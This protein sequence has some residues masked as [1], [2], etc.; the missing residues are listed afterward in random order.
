MAL[1]GG[2]Q[3]APEIGGRVTFSTARGD[4]ISEDLATSL[5]GP[6]GCLDRPAA[7]DPSKHCK[8]FARGDL[9]NRPAAEP[10]EHI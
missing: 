1:L 3:R 5:L 2:R 8:E 9:C 7:F 6:V 10:R 4:G